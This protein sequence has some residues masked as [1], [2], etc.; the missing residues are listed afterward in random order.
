[1]AAE[2]SIPATARSECKEDAPNLLDFLVQLVYYDAKVLCLLGVIGSPDNLQQSLMGERLSLLT[3]QRARR[4]MPLDSSGL[5]YR[6]LRRFSSR[7]PHSI[8]EFRFSEGALRKCIFARPPGCVPGAR[9]WRRVSQHSHP[10]RTERK[11]LIVFR[12]S[13]GDLKDNRILVQTSNPLMPGMFTS[14][15]IRPGRSRMTISMA[16]PPLFASIT[17]KPLLESV[18]SKTRR[19]CGSSSATRM[20]AF[21]VAVSVF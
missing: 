20:V 12:I 4:R 16:S 18:A 19:I 6:G 11:N 5:S 8:P 14:K 10:P 15:K 9:R 2:I 13:A 7:D 1:L 17:S 3:Y 21:G